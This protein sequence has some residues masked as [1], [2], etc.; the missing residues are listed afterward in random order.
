LAALG[1]RPQI[2]N[3]VQQ[4]ANFG[5]GEIRIHYQPGLL[6]ECGLQA[7]A[8]QGVA[9][10]GAQPAL[11]HDRVCH[12]PAGRAVP[13]DGGFPLV[14]DAHAGNVRGCEPGASDG[15][16]RSCELGSPDRLRVMF[17]VSRLRVKLLKFPLRDGD[18]PPLTVEN[19]GA[20][21][22][23][24]LVQCE[25]VMTHAGLIFSRIHSFCNPVLPGREKKTA[26]GTA[27]HRGSRRG[28]GGEHALSHRI[29]A[30]EA[31]CCLA[32]GTT[33]LA[34]SG[35]PCFAMLITTTCGVRQF[36]PANTTARR[37]SPVWKSRAREPWFQLIALEIQGH[38]APSGRASEVLTVGCAAPRSARTS[39][40]AFAT[41]R[42]GKREPAAE[43]P[44][45]A[46][47]MEPAGVLRCATLTESSSLFVRCFRT[48]C[49]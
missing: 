21:G 14:G 17:H 41:V 11:P 26:A 3:S 1:A 47:G 4:V 20:A 5:S 48:A 2:G 25:D 24:P 32:F 16:S 15:F 44:A 31:G 38:R 30:R 49:F 42:Q 45:P 43:I 22:C 13:Q 12:R 27:G 39:L 37:T 33:E 36:A 34:L 18:D 46:A 19:N 35:V 6:A 7:V 40:V 23:R 8:L 28:A 29:V 10:A 9:D